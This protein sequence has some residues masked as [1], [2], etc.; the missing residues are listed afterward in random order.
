MKVS[1]IF[2]SPRQGGNTDCLLEELLKGAASTGAEID[3]IYVRD[4]KIAP[5]EAHMV[6]HKTGECIIRDD[7]QKVYKQLLS[8][9]VVVLAAPVFFYNLPAQTKALIDR[10]Q[11]LWARKYILKKQPLTQTKQG[12]PRQGF[13]ISTGGTKG[14]NLFEGAIL[15]VKYFFDALG[16]KYSGE[17]V[18]RGIDHKGAIRQHPTALEDVFKQGSALTKS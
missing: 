16:V 15:T 1:G 10:T 7:M 9:D 2:G 17:Q 5:C 13:F 12:I 4:L 11:V 8:T 6:C 3:K 14:V 18:F